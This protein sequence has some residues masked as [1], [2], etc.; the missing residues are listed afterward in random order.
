[1][2]IAPIWHRLVQ[3]R[4]LCGSDCGR[5]LKVSRLCRSQGASRHGRHGI[6]SGEHC[7]QH[8]GECVRN[9]Q[10]GPE[11]EISVWRQRPTHYQ[12]QD[13]ERERQQE[14]QASPANAGIT[15]KVV[16]GPR[17]QSGNTSCHVVTLGPCPNRDPSYGLATVSGT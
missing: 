2:T 13:S 17:R 1:M 7:Q 3:A 10:G 12:E 5:V 6:L 4:I 8:P 16:L 9:T 15:K 11:A 14:E